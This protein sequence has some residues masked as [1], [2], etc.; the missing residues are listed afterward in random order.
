MVLLSQSSGSWRP[1]SS[2]Y[3][4][5]TSLVSHPTNVAPRPYWFVACTKVT[6]FFTLTAQVN[7]LNLR[8]AMKDLYLRKKARARLRVREEVNRGKE[9]KLREVGAV[10]A[11]HF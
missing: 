2:P 3:S 1:S 4:T 9:S 10:I 5:T 7:S 6:P 11:K 8:L